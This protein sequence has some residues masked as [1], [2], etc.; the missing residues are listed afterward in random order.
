MAS[1]SQ[2]PGTPS[3]SLSLS[4]TLI[5]T[6]K[7][8]GTGNMSL[9]ITQIERTAH[10]RVRVDGRGRWGADRGERWERSPP[11][12]LSALITSFSLAEL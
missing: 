2:N 12:R 10:G 8:P 5:D 1:S 6:V 4:L 7:G 3:I 11:L 9:G